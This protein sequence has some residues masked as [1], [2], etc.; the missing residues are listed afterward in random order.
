MFEASPT[1]AVMTAQQIYLALVVGAFSTF[2]VS[3]FAA[4]VWS[5]RK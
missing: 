4:A 5:R 2:A 3:L 1:E